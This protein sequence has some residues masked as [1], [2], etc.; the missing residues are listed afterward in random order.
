MVSCGPDGWRL[1]QLAV[2]MT[3]VYLFCNEPVSSA[4]EPDECSLQ[5]LIG[6]RVMGKMAD[7]GHVKCYVGMSY[8]SITQSQNKQIQ[9]GTGDRKNDGFSIQ[10][11]KSVIIDDK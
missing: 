8:N 10:R 11:V 5:G 4:L 6:I 7:N 9:G 1:Q 3:N 2:M